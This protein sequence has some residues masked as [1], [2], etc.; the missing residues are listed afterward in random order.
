MPLWTLDEL[1]KLGQLVPET[2]SADISGVSIDSRQISHGDFFI[3]LSGDPGPRFKG[4]VDNPKDG[5]DFISGAVANGASAILLAKPPT[6]INVPYVQVEDTLDGLW[7]MARLSRGR[8]QGQVVAITGSAGKTTAKSWLGA[9]LEPLCKVHSSIGSLNNHWGVP[10]SLSRMSANA[11]VGVIEIGT[12]HPGEIGPLS[13]LS[14]PHVSVLLNVLPAHIGNFES[15]DA[16]R[17]EK[18]SI[19]SGLQEGGK[20]VL[21]RSLGSGAAHEVTFG[22]EPDADATGSY[23]V[24]GADWYVK[25]NICGEQVEY[26]LAEEG[27]HRV[28][29]SLAVLA[30]VS[31]L[32]YSVTEAA[33]NLITA[34]SP[35][36]RGNKTRIRDITVIDDSYNANPVSMLYAINSFEGQGRK[37]ALLGEMLELGDD[38][39]RYHD[40]VAQHFSG[41]DQVI[42]V[43]EGF[44][45]AQGDT[46]FASIQDINIDAF[47]SELRPGDEVLVK[48]SNKVFW[49]FGFVDRLLEKLKAS[50]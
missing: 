45:S 7:D 21:H 6:N 46:H 2:A 5:H 19:A 28:L 34:D 25:A 38:S 42:T 3:A 35:K 26:Q 23:E 48:G 37:I 43:G 44:Q 36:G 17:A 39:E 10:L 4:G 15:L 12:N 31:Q 22:L 33:Q 47:V 40:E 27:E 41:L 11:D 20:F 16:L 13:D 29:T 49:Q 8:Y 1:A 14:A 18:L 24:R 50:L 9:V 32:G 30:V